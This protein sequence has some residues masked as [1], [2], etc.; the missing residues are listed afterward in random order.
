[1]RKT[2]ALRAMAVSDTPVAMMEAVNKV[3]H[4]N[5]KPLKRWFYITM[6]WIASR[7]SSFILSQNPEDVQTAYR[8]F[9][10]HVHRGDLEGIV[11]VGRRILDLRETITPERKNPVD[12]ELFRSTHHYIRTT[13]Y[14]S[15]GE[16]V[17]R[18]FALFLEV[19]F[20][21]S[22]YRFLARHYAA[23]SAADEAD[24]FFER[25]FR[26][27]PDDEKLK[28]YHRQYVSDTGRKQP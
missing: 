14:R 27:C 18:Y 25:A 24:A 10:K 28:A 7:C 6:E 22:I 5:M 2:S 12:D 9:I 20:S 15:G 3:I 8:L 21:K 1:L 23:G 4:E 17:L 13:L 11:T 16:A 26:D 19:T